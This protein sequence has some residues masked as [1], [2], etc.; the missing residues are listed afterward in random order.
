MAS[1]DE[2]EERERFSRNEF[3]EEIYRALRNST[4]EILNFSRGCLRLMNDSKGLNVV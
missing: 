1:G 2:C 3:Y 4:R